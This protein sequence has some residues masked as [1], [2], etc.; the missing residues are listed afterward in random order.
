MRFTNAMSKYSVPMHFVL[1]ICNQFKV[2]WSII[3]SD[4]VNVVDFHTIGYFA[5]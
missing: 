3:V 4:A 5:V 1:A 2:L